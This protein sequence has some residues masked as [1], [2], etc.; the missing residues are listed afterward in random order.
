MAKVFAP[1]NFSDCRYR[2]TAIL[3]DCPTVVTGAE[4]LSSLRSSAAMILPTPETALL[5]AFD[6][7]FKA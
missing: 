4:P 2:R 5:T 6:T 7:S 3:A 1:N